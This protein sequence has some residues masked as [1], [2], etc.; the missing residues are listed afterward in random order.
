MTNDYLKD[1]DDWDEQ[2]Q[3][4]LLSLAKNDEFISFEELEKGILRKAKNQLNSIKTN[5]SFQ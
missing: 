2:S 1:L 5:Q 4:I 3:Q